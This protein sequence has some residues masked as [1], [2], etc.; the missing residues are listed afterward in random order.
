MKKGLKRL[1]C[2]LL[3]AGMIPSAAL[4]TFAKQSSLDYT[5]L[6]QEDFSQGKY[7]EKSRWASGTTEIVR[8]E[9]GDFALKITKGNSLLIRFPK[10]I[11]SGKLTI[12][13]DFYTSD[14]FSKSTAFSANLTEGRSA[15]MMWFQGVDENSDSVI[16][17][18]RV[19]TGNYG[20][21]IQP[22]ESKKWYRLRAV[23]DIAQNS[24]VLKCGEKESVAIYFDNITNA[25]P[26][27]LSNGIH[28]IELSNALENDAYYL[29]D[30]LA[31]Y[32]GEAPALQSPQNLEIG[33][34]NY[35]ISNS[36]GKFKGEMRLAAPDDDNYNVISA[37]KNE[38][39]TIFDIALITPNSV[40]NHS[41]NV[42]PENRYTH[43][44]FML[45]KTTLAPFVQKYSAE[46]LPEGEANI[47]ELLS[48]I[49]FGS[50]Q[51]LS[52]VKTLY[53]ERRYTEAIKK[54]KSIFFARMKKHYDEGKIVTAVDG[55]AAKGKSLYETNKTTI[56]FTDGVNHVL[57]FGTPGSYYWWEETQ[58]SN[59]LMT[60]MQ[61]LM[62][63]Y[64][65]YGDIK[66]FDR[67]T[68]MWED[69][70]KHFVENAPTPE[71]R[72][73]ANSILRQGLGVA[74]ITERSLGD[75]YHALAKDY[76]SVVN[77]ISND[78]FISLIRLWQQTSTDCTVLVSTPNQCISA[79][80]YV[81][82]LYPA[83]SDFVWGK[84]NLDR[85]VSRLDVYL[86]ENYL[87]DGQDAEM[88]FNYNYGLIRN[89]M[90]IKNSLSDYNLVPDY[91]FQNIAR[92]RLRSMSA[93]LSPQG[94][95][96]NIGK[97]FDSYNQNSYIKEYSAIV[98]GEELADTIRAHVFEG[99]E[100]VPAFNSIAFPYA[101]YY[102]LRDG[103]DND[104]SY[105]FFRSGRHNIGHSDYQCLQLMLSAFGERLLIAAGPTAYSK[106]DIDD[107]LTSSFAGNTVTVDGYS[108]VF[109]SKTDSEDMHSVIP[110]RFHDGGWIAYTEGEY[111]NGYGII[112][113]ADLTAQEKTVT[114]I[115]HAR[116]LITDFENGI[117]VTADT[118]NQSGMNEHEYTLNWNL[119]YKFNDLS[120]ADITEN[121]FSTNNN[122]S[123]AGIEIQ[124]F[125]DS[126]INYSKYCGYSAPEDENTGDERS[127]KGW[128][129]QNYGTDYKPSLH[130]EGTWKTTSIS[131]E[132]LSLIVPKNGASP[133]Q[134]LQKIGKNGFV[135]T[136]TNG[137]SV[138][139]SAD[140]F[141]LDSI[142]A[143]G[144]FFYIVKDGNNYKGIA[145]DAQTFAIGNTLI[146]TGSFEFDFVNGVVTKKTITIH[147]GFKWTKTNAGYIPEY[148]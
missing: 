29:I 99:K 14:F 91:D 111:D 48:E 121:G 58:F 130:I 3:C 101:G 87:P 28:E 25:T 123:G 33:F 50:H 71:D 17:N 117:Y 129:L 133:V 79:I 144:G 145:I 52:A 70:Q 37:I 140:D 74:P 98:G 81:C 20:T 114:G 1:T 47:K 13:F 8:Q 82:M 30:N 118:L 15:N 49:D 76:D 142:Y 134:S 97:T 10:V 126:D 116:K 109:N 139:C 95:L 65:T 115:R 55:N 59:S 22:F 40:I 46:I 64:L 44:L 42:D 92:T 21:F 120:Y 23:L 5:V 94:K 54:Y 4:T 100:S 103:W 75:L 77:S 67:W 43:E 45:N 41:T 9:D 51:E 18:S 135:A 80:A 106:L 11:K 125:A 113:N 31:V 89:C 78:E 86:A 39:G 66:Y 132:A 110:A 131:S 32:E 19:R 53:D 69:F 128:Y 36:N 88:S 147:A 83:V 63:A 107:Y 112:N 96:P 57:D 148:K 122:A 124:T 119:A 127:Y 138:Y 68:V 34:D 84:D 72:K 93:L 35:A 104:S 102:A 27:Y 2:L 26:T 141:E 73:N 137:R 90:K 146:G 136:L 60:F 62:Q 7:K 108:Q 61:D 56:F 12:D 143:D 105:A 6:M 38:N 24:C 16:D 85:A